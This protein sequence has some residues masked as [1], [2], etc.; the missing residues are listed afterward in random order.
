MYMWKVLLL[1]VVTMQ[2]RCQDDG[3]RIG[4]EGMMSI[5]GW[6]AAALPGWACIHCCIQW[7]QIHFH[8]CDDSLVAAG[9]SSSGV[10]E[11]PPGRRG[12]S[13]AAAASSSSRRRTRGSS[14]GGSSSGCVA[15]QQQ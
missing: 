10:S 6:W 12:R 7:H 11:T 13:R 9:F 1:A 5:I 2:L 4:V 8:L 15:V 14:T 3:G